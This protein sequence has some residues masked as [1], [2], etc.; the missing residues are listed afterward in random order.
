MLNAAM[1]GNL[2]NVE[3]VKIQD[4]VEIPV[5]CPT[6]VNYYNQKYMGSY[7]EYDETAN[8][9]VS[10]FNENFV[11]YSAGVSMKLMRLHPN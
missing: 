2:D 11:R 4:L 1:D 8:K 5:E 9:L 7:E 10:M 6:L 3:Y